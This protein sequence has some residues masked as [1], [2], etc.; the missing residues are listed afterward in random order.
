MNRSFAPVLFGLVLVACGG[1]PPPVAQSTPTAATT[2]KPA[3]A[4]TTPETSAAPAAA[5]VIIHEVADYKAWRT[6]FDG[7]AAAR[8]RA[9]ITQAHVNQAADNPNLVTVYLA[10]DSAASIQAFASD[11]EVK[12]TMI[13]GGVKGEPMVIAITPVED[14]TIKDRALPAALIRFKV[15]NYETWK[16]A[17]DGN[18][19]DRTKAG[20]IGHAVNR[21]SADMS[22]VIVYLQSESLD[23]LRT[24]TSSPELRAV[25]QRAGVQG[26]PQISFV[27][28]GVWGQ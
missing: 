8:K 14:K 17:F 24:F 1:A 23:S 25:Q 27:Q 26:P 4:T 9:K 22:T 10:A 28:G 20:I 21:V 19:A 13:K 15:A 18:A 6:V 12:T 3:P 5:A 7:H 11:P 2:D 16:S